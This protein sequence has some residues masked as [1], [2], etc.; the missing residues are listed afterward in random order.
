MSDEHFEHFEDR[1]RA[2]RRQATEPGE[3]EQ[4][5]MS[6]LGAMWE[7]DQLTGPLVDDLVAAVREAAGCGNPQS[8]RGGAGGWDFE[9]CGKCAGCRLIAKLAALD[10]ASRG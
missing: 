9:D 10:E 6:R 8:V 7:F 3:Y 1:H 5:L 2:L 4:P